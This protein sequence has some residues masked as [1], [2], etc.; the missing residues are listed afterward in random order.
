LVDQLTG[1][2]HTT[3]NDLPVSIGKLQEELKRARREAEELRL[4]LASGAVSASSANGNEVREVAG[5]KV[6]ARE[7][8]ELDASGVRQLS[9]TLLARV[10]SGIVVLG[11]R[12]DGKVS[13]IVRTSKDLHTRV[14]AGQVRRDLAP[15]IG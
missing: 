15:I 7:A 11:R 10:Q 3:R 4:K 13:L 9:D 8:S 12:A 14:P 5:V 2:L 6:L 1:E